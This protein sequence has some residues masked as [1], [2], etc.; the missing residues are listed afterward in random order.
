LGFAHSKPLRGVQSACGVFKVQGS[1][2]KAAA[3]RYLLS[4]IGYSL[5][6]FAF[7]DN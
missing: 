3:Q 6:S 4:V 2:F 5:R 1:R 7:P